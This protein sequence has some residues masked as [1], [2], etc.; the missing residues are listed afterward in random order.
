MQG[1]PGLQDTLSLSKQSPPDPQMSVL[2]RS[3]HPQIPGTATLRKSVCGFI[4]TDT[5]LCDQPRCCRQSLGC[6]H[7]RAGVTC[8]EPWSPLPKKRTLKV[9]SHP[10]LLAS[11]SSPAS[12]CD[13][14]HHP[15]QR[16]SD[17]FSSLHK[18]PHTIRLRQVNLVALL[19]GH[20]R[21]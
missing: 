8:R 19:S 4:H 5:C 11:S 21:W 9:L 20:H 12:C 1:Q 18:N 17:L 7:S 2:L 13:I 16:E 6:S 3:T 15:G 10:I 14:A